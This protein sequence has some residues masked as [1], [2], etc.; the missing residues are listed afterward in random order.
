MRKNLFLIFLITFL[1]S[2]GGPKLDDS[3]IK[4]PTTNESGDKNLSRSI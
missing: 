2:C 4:P 3:L 1:L